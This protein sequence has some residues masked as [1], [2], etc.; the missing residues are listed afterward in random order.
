MCFVGASS[1]LRSEQLLREL[2]G[3]LLLQDTEVPCRVCRNPQLVPNRS[4]I[5]LVYALAHYFFYHLN[6][7]LLPTHMYSQ[8]FYFFHGLR[9]KVFIHFPY[10]LC[11]L[12]DQPIAS[13]ICPPQY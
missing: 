13:L 8:M 9:L 12:H 10:L 3:R 5:S 7:I 11:V 4:Q 1:F 6:I 2:K